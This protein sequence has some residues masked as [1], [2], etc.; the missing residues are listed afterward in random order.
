MIGKGSKGERI[1]F[2]IPAYS[3]KTSTLRH[4]T[5]CLSLGL[6]SRSNYQPPRTWRR[7]QGRESGRGAFAIGGH[8]WRCKSC[9]FATSV[10]RRIRELRICLFL[11]E[12]RSVW[13]EIKRPLLG[14]YSCNDRV[15]LI[16]FLT[17]GR[18]LLSVL[19]SSHRQFAGLIRL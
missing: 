15:N 18:D 19:L 13:W 10:W 4:N 17:E 9:W 2:D 1:S 16:Q 11:A 6:P 7:S 3:I 5:T 12:P 14:S 8:R